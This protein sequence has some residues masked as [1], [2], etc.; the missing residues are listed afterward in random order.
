MG[1]C[2]WDVLKFFVFIINFA[3]LI[4]AG[5]ILGLT[6]FVLVKSDDILGFHIDPDLSASNPTAI[7]FSLALI[8][9]VVFGFMVLFTF[10]GC[11][12]AACQNRCMLGS[13]IIILFIF[14]GANIAAIAYLFMQF[15]NEVELATNE[16]EKTIPYYDPDDDH[17][18]VRLFWD[19]LQPTLACCG[20][21]SWQDWGAA[22]LKSNRQ[23]PSS[24]CKKSNDDDPDDCTFSPTDANSY[25]GTGCMSQ[26]E[27][28]FRIAFWTLPSLMA[29][30][31]ISALIVC[32]KSRNAPGNRSNRRSRLSGEYSEETGYVYRSSATPEYPTAPPFNPDYPAPNNYPGN[33]HSNPYADH[34][35]TGVIPPSSDFSSRQPLI[36]PPPYHDV[37]SRPR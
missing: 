2:C 32:S 24:C 16:L 29:L 28:P 4:A 20:A 10:L 33:P 36:Q 27:L 15:P 18:L 21:T 6:I 25:A 9:I 19:W 8:L 30:I 3:A 22:Q 14:L 1:K 7:Y 13:F 26:M 34:Y 5:A 37:V 11:C 35:P 17:S 31:L 12:G 23:V